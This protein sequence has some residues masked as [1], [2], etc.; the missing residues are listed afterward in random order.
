VRV[1]RNATRDTLPV[2]GLVVQKL[3]V[4]RLRRSVI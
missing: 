1:D 3:D 4:Q 2:S